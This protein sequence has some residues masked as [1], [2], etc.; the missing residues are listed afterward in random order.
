M[1]QQKGKSVMGAAFILIVGMITFGTINTISIPTLTI[2]ML[3]PS[4]EGPD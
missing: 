1:S 4:F 3:N 2:T